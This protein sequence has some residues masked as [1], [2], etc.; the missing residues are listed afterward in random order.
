M[1]GGEGMKHFVEYLLREEDGQ[2]LAEYSMI[3]VLIAIAALM[4]VGAAGDT[5][6]KYY[7]KILA[8]VTSL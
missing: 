7:D 6:T 1:I 8:A 2:G 5:V 4:S 3:I